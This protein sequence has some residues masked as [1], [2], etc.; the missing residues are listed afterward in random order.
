MGCSSPLAGRVMLPYC[1]SKVTFG[2]A[3]FNG[4][5]A[6]K[7]LWISCQSITSLKSIR[8]V[9]E[10]TMISCVY[11]EFWKD[12]L[13]LT[14]PLTGPDSRTSTHGFE[15]IFHTTPV[16]LFDRSMRGMSLPSESP[17]SSMSC[18]KLPSLVSSI[19]SRLFS[20]SNM[21]FTYP[22]MGEILTLKKAFSIFSSFAFMGFG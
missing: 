4:N 9:L 5:E 13:I 11:L 10:Y 8:F 7:A 15:S 19:S 18:S 1:V 14:L 22:V 3:M 2:L 20:L 12:L 17:I 6:F 16:N 21:L